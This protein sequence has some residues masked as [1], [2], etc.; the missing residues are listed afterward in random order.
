MASNEPVDI[1][2]ES[3]PRED[4]MSEIFR[5]LPGLHYKTAI[6]VPASGMLRVYRK[7]L[8]GNALTDPSQRP[9]PSKLVKLSAGLDFDDVR[10][11]ILGK[12]PHIQ[13]WNGSEKNVLAATFCSLCAGGYQHH[14]YCPTAMRR[15]KGVW[16]RALADYWQGYHRAFFGELTPPEVIKS[17]FTLG[18]LFGYEARRSAMTPS[19]PSASASIPHD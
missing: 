16:A 10:D 11:A 1:Q 9:R 7:R 13:A 4:L 18:L 8:G 2:I 5:Q 14:P 15:H 6:Y 17:S 3:A 12:Y 19:Q